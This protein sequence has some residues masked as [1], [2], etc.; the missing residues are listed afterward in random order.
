MRRGR[1][2]GCLLVT[3]GFRRWKKSVRRAVFLEARCLRFA[4][5]RLLILEELRQSSLSAQ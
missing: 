2:P 5:R 3:R 4:C 1:V